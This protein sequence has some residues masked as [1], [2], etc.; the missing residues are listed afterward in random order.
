MPSQIAKYGSL[1]QES[2]RRTSNVWVYRY[3]ETIK[4]KKSK[5]KRIVGTVKE[6]PTHAAANQPLTKI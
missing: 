4:G 1:T 3:F 5:R 6:Y 2:R